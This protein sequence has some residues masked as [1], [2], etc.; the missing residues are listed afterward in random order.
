[1]VTQTI[2]KMSYLIIFHNE[3]W[4]GLA[5]IDVD[6]ETRHLTWSWSREWQSKVKSDES[7]QNGHKS[8]QLAP[9]K[10]KDIPDTTVDTQQHI[11]TLKQLKWLPAVAKHWLEVEQQQLLAPQQQQPQQFEPPQQIESQEREQQQQQGDSNSDSTII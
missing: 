9:D 7:R 1:M 3:N 10:K 8:S 11:T 2:L 4:N 5:E 6:S